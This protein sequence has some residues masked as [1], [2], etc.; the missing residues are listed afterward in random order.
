MLCRQALRY[1]ADASVA[2]QQFEEGKN[3]KYRVGMPLWRTAARAGIEL[4][5]RV[6]VHFDEESRSYWAASKDLDGLVVSGATLDELRD[7]VISA[8]SVL[9]E[10]QLSEFPRHITADMHVTSALCAA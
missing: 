4:H 8:A 3:M 1:S 2:L 7:E 10:G 6:D 9:L 5:V